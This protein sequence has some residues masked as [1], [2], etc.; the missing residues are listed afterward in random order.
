VHYRQ[1]D[2][3]AAHAAEEIVEAES[4][5]LRTV[6]AFAKNPKPDELEPLFEPVPTLCCLY[7]HWGFREERK[8]RVIAI[9]PNATLLRDGRTSGEARPHHVSRTFVGDGC[10]VPYIDLFG[11]TSPTAELVFL[12]ITRVLVGPHPQADNRKRAVE[13]MLEACGIE[14]SV[15]VSQ[16]PYIGG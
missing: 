3:D 7:K 8:V 9:P 10:P 6:V 1:D 11:R 15:A 14:A 5:L 2:A 16:I 12:P 13:I 4:K